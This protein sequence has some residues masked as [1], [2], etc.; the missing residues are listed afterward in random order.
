MSTRCQIGIYRTEDQ[1]IKKP[2]VLLYRHSDGYPGKEDGSEY[3]VLADLVPFLRTFQ[4]KRGIR[5]VEYCGAWL[6]HHLVDLHV[7]H[8]K[9]FAKDFNML[10]VPTDGKDFLGYGVSKGFYGDIE[11]FYKITP[12]ALKVYSVGGSEDL[13]FNLEQVITLTK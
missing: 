13:E 11:Y 8:T 12:N 4:E 9:E 1:D 2:D 3:G 6:M 5:D 10:S 7:Q